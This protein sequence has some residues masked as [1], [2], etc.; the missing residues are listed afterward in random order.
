MR[1]FADG[2]GARVLAAHRKGMRWTSRHDERNIKAGI[3]RRVRHLGHL[4]I[5]RFT[6]A[7][8]D[9]G[10][11]FGVAEHRLI[12]HKRLHLGPSSQWGVSF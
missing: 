12:N 4:H 6:N 1:T 9:R 10:H 2:I 8:C 7:S 3:G 5:N 11:L